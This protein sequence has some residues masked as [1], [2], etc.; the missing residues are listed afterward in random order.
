[1]VKLSYFADASTLDWICEGRLSSVIDDH[2]VV[3]NMC[4]SA[5]GYS[6]HQKGW[7]KP[8][9]RPQPGSHGNSAVKP[10]NAGMVFEWVTFLTL[11][12]WCSLPPMVHPI[13]VGVSR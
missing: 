9:A 13:I 5:I 7:L 2:Y 10:P 11:G 12:F 3:M 4:H 1:M 8:M 6:K